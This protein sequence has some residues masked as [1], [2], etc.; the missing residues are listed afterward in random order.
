MDGPSP[1]FV[2]NLSQLNPP[3]MSHIASRGSFVHLKK[4]TFSYLN[5][6]RVKCFQSEKDQL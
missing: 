2:A 4:I 5:F 3:D 6:Q 1:A